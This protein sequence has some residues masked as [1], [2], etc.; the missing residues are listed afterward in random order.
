M[1]VVEVVVVR[2]AVSKRP[3]GERCVTRTGIRQR[4]S[5]RPTAPSLRISKTSCDGI[6]DA[7]SR[8][9]HKRGGDMVPD[10]VIH[11]RALQTRHFD[12]GVVIYVAIGT[13]SIQTVLSDLLLSDHINPIS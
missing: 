6:L 10:T 11:T 12:W 3:I 13:P 8:A 1:N 4:F 9:Q 2:S 7:K 5:K